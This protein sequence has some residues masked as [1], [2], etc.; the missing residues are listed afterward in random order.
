VS[1]GEAWLRNDHANI[2]PSSS[3]IVNRQACPLSDYMP[4]FLAVR[5]LTGLLCKPVRLLDLLQK[6]GVH[7]AYNPL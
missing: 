2:P 3:I 5:A 1:K 7:S 4:P 6:G